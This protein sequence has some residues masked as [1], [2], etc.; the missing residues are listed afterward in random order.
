MLATPT[1]TIPSGPG[2]AHEVKWDGMRILA[3]VHEARL[4]LTSRAGRDVTSAFPELQPLARTF[5]D[6]LLDGEVVAL[7][8]GRSSFAALTERMHVRDPQR[9]ARKAA[10]RPVTYMI[11][12]LVRLFGTDLAGQPWS[13][14]R[15]LLDQLD[16][17][18][19]NWQVPAVHEDGESLWAAT[20]EQGLEGVVS[21]RRDSTYAAGRRSTDWLKR[22][23]RTTLSAV[24]GGWRPQVDRDERLGAVLLGLPDGDGGWRYAGRMGSGLAGA[25]GTRLH[26]QLT[27][28]GRSSSPFST[29]VPPKDSDLTRW[30]DPVI[31]VDVRTLGGHEQSRLRQPTFR[32]TRSDVSPGDLLAGG[33][34]SS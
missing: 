4:V 16:L 11:F 12:D 33:S 32:G 26:A 8:G 9:A 1:D 25:A 24:V 17:N 14:R 5:P 7:D 15:E 29:E 34:D 19:T 18:G 23:H 22:A 3:D 21:K 10:T 2:W 13:A 6:L 31:V 30:V 20:R 28:L 27:S